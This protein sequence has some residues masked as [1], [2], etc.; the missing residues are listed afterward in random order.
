MPRTK[1]APVAKRGL[2]QDTLINDAPEEETFVT[3]PERVIRKKGSKKVK[4]NYQFAIESEFEQFLSEANF[5][6]TIHHMEASE[7]TFFVIFNNT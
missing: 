6:L 3:Q 1:S 7:Y 5:F 2:P 4:N